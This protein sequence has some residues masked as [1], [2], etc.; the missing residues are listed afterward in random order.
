M[1]TVD[2]KWVRLFSDE[3]FAPYFQQLSPFSDASCQRIL[4]AMTSAEP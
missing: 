4:P 2:F 1:T 3:L